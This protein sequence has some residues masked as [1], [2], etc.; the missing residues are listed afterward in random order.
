MR[1]DPLNDLPEDLPGRR[2]S[3]RLESA[4]GLTDRIGLV[5][6]VDAATLTLQDRTGVIHP[7]ARGAIRWAR[8]VP[9]V[10]RGRNPRHAPAAVVTAL[11]RD[12]V[13]E[14]FGGPCWMARLCDLVDHLDDSGVRR[15]T[16][17]TATRGDSRGLVNGEWSALRLATATDLRPLAAW[18]ARHNARNVVLTSRLPDAEL[19]GLG[20][21]QV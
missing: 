20:L 12:P 21:Q 11:A 13:L 5:L 14:P 17:T 2:V 19:T 4:D 8:A 3:L 6:S 10:P 16:A 7:I 9:T 1:T 18:A 15:L